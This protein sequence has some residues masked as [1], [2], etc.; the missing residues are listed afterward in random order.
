MHFALFLSSTT[1]FNDKWAISNMQ[2]LLRSILGLWLESLSLECCCD[3][4][5]FVPTSLGH[6][7]FC[8]LSLS[9]PSRHQD[10]RND[11]FI[12]SVLVLRCFRHRKYR[13]RR[14]S[15]KLKILAVDHKW[16][17]RQSVESKIPASL[18]QKSIHGFE[19]RC[20]M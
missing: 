6:S 1:Y 7:S 15:K 11:S 5:V 13:D 14:S 20:V 19:N 17:A 18:M 8:L 12:A 4:L 10:H 2:L 16:N 3:T 9:T